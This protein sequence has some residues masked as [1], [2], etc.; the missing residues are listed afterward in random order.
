MDVSTIISNA[1][2]TVEDKAVR[3]LNAKF[4]DSFNDLLELK[5]LKGENT[6]YTKV[7][8]GDHGTKIGSM[9]IDI[10]PGKARYFNLQITPDNALRAPRYVFEGMV[11]GHS[12]QL[13][14]D[15][16][17]DTDIVTDLN[18]VYATYEPINKLFEEIRK[19]DIFTPS[20]S[21]YLHIRSFCSPVF[22][23]APALSIE[24]VATFEGYAEQYFDSWLAIVTNAESS[25]AKETLDRKERRDLISRETIAR[26]PD[27]KMV[28]GVYGEELTRRIE[29]AAMSAT[30]LI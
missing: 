5:N 29:E 14:V 30:A 13:S 6:G 28:V 22:L 18:W 12:S 21:R 17:P 2:K 25:D 7:W 20:V 3:V 10:M 9:S 11:M 8:H 27:R 19:G 23:L 24:T 16:Y 26:D 1:G 15:L 4:D